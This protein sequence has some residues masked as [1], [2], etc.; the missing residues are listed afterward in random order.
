MISSIFGRTKP[1]NYIILLVFLFIFYWFVHFFVFQ[2]SYSPKQ[3]LGQT[4]ILGILSFSIFVVNFIALRNK[5][6]GGNSLAILFYILLIVLFPEVLIDANAIFCS[7]FLLLSIRRILSF[8]SLK[9]IK[10]KIFDA[11]FWIMIA[12]L[13]YDWAI[14]YLLVVI[15]AIY[16]YEPKNIKNWLVP[17]A[18]IIAMAL[19][20]LAVLA[21][22]NNM[23]F[24]WN[25]YYFDFRFNAVYF[26]DWS[27]ST[28][29]FLYV[30][31]VLLCGFLAFLKLGSLGV[32]K[33]VTMRLIVLLFFIGLLV[34]VLKSTPETHPILITFFPAVVFI[35]TYIQSIKKASLRE[36][37]LMVSVIVPF[38]VFLT[39]T[40]MK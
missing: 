2:K 35:T 16:F 18:A 23:D 9:D 25:H 1:I 22:G 6:T 38:I 5:I 11:T 3:L 39:N 20:M 29:L 12:S 37:V 15:V 21:L 13:F 14:L 17:F 24:L 19:I 8:R 31:I 27:N 28:L 33:I 10:L 32:G 40:L 7:F 36:I 30:S 34:K 4:A 26:Y